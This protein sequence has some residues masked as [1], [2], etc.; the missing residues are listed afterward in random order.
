[1]RGDELEGMGTLVFNP[2]SRVCS[3]SVSFTFPKIYWYA[4]LQENK[5]A[6]SDKC[7]ESVAKPT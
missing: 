3:D 7:G 4:F 1:M 6:V 2:G 5:Y